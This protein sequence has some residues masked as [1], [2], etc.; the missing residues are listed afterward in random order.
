MTSAGR[1]LGQG[2]DRLRQSPKSRAP[3]NFVDQLPRHFIDPALR[4]SEG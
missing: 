1:V 3:R 2:I 4:S